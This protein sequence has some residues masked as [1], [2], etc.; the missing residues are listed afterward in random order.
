MVY[1]E[2]NLSIVAA[3]SVFTQDGVVG[4]VFSFEDLESLVSWRL[5]RGI[6]C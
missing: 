6:L 5:V 4:G 1:E 2:N 3:R